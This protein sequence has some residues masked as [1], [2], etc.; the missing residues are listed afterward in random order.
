MAMVFGVFLA[1]AVT[2]GVGGGSYMYGY[3]L[4]PSGCCERDISRTV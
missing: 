2:K 4:R 3:G 1:P